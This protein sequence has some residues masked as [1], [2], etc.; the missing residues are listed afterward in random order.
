MATIEQ[1]I[2]ALEQKRIRSTDL[3]TWTDEE[4]L[5]YLGLSHDVTDEHLLALA[6][7]RRGDTDHAHT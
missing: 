3:T 2:M 6:T 7:G 1:R 5:D 4:L